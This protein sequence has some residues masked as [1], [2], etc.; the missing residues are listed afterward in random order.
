[1]QCDELVYNTLMDGC[2]KANEA[3]TAP[4]VELSSDQR[5]AGGFKK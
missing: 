5:L 2:V 3:S 1:M 4:E